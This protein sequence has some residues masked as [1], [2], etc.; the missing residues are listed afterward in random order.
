MPDFS[1]CHAK[2]ERAKHN[3]REF[4][5]ALGAFVEA[6]QYGLFAEPD[7]KRRW[8]YGYQ[9][10]GDQRRADER[11]ANSARHHRDPG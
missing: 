6:A 5:G 9:V 7:R 11:G 3:S 4:D 2:L 8:P 10:V 1:S